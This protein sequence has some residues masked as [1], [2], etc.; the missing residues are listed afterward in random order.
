[1]KL[2]PTQAQ[3]DH[4][5]IMVEDRFC[6]DFSEPGTGKTL[7]ALLA[8]KKAGLRNLLIIVPTIVREQWAQQAADMFN[9]DQIQVL[10]TGKDKID[11]AKARILIVTYGIAK[12]KE[13]HV[14][15]C[16]WQAMGVI[17]DEAHALKGLDT[18]ATKA[19]YGAAKGLPGIIDG[20]QYVWPL[21][22]TPIRRYPDDLYPMLRAL[23][24]RS[25][26][27]PGKHKANLSYDDFLNRFCVVE[28]R[29]F[30]NMRFPTSVITGA[31]NLE[32]LKDITDSISVKRYLVEMASEL[33]PV[34]F[35]TLNVPMDEKAILS[36]LLEDD[37]DTYR[38]LLNS[39][40][41]FDDKL[42]SM[43]ASIE[44]EQPDTFLA[45][46]RAEI[47]RQ[48]ATDKSLIQY[49]V[50]LD[51]PVTLAGFT[52]TAFDIETESAGFV[53]ARARFLGL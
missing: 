3:E 33:P 39:K 30:G 7:T 5:D 21:T 17:L 11:L 53:A 41:S 12:R 29:R 4:S 20:A 26:A 38:E 51:D 50:D 43:L 8:A 2:T 48:K 36:A 47:G 31:K 40:A 46:V 9:P 27:K 32:K 10:K 37:E 34:T 52:A 49:I 18:Q 24:P 19:V 23:F 25:M 28:K 22:G 15:L 44:G 13:M 1:M 16:N 42:K 35:G 6:A 45:T 14:Q